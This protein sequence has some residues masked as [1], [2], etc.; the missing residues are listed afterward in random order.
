MKR[1]AYRQVYGGRPRKPDPDSGWSW[2][3]VIIPLVTAGVLAVAW[4]VQ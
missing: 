2:W 1:W 3:L 4:G